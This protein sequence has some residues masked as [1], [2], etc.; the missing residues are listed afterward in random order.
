MQTPVVELGSVYIDGPYGFTA[1]GVIREGRAVKFTAAENTVEEADTADEATYG[2][3]ITDATDGEAVSVL[4]E[5]RFDR[6]VC[7]AELATANVAL[8]VDNQGRYVAAGSMDAIAGHNRTVTAA[9]GDLFLIELEPADVSI[10]A[11]P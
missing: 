9:A 3:A 5:G 4:R 1:S 2:V 7:G 10:P 6:A 8:T 11:A